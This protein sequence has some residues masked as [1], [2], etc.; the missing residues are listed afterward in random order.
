MHIK[1]INSSLYCE[2]IMHAYTILKTYCIR[3]VFSF[4]IDEKEY[5]NFLEGQI[6]GR[7]ERKQVNI[8]HYSD[9][10]YNFK[11]VISRKI[12]NNFQT[13]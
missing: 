6:S 12:K 13:Y 9:V 10:V 11:N 4:L 2:R 1:Y 7:E 5:H 3:F 8:Y